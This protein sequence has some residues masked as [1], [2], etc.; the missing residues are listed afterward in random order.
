MEIPAQAR[1]WWSPPATAADSHGQPVTIPAA[2][3]EASFDGGQTW[4]PS[5]DNAGVPGWLVAGA[6]YPGPG[7]SD[8]GIVP[9]HVMGDLPIRPH[10]R[11]RDSPETLIDH[12]LW[13]TPG[14]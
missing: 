12:S 3:L 14:P 4:V 6:D 13:L 11:L 8:G 7:D 2:G 1:L 9:D 10:V 5:R